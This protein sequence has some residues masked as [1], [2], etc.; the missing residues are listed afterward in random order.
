MEKTRGKQN[1]ILGKLLALALTLALA[2]GSIP[3]AMAATLLDSLFRPGPGPGKYTAYKVEVQS[4][5]VIIATNTVTYDP[6]GGDGDAVPVTVNRGAEHTV[7]NQGFIRGGYSFTGW[8]TEALG[9]GTP[10]AV[11][12]VITNVTNDITLYAQWEI[13]TYTITYHPN[14]GD[15]TAVTVKVNSGSDH[16]VVS[17]NYKYTLPLPHNFKGWNTEAL[18]GGTPYSVDSVITNVTSDIT[19]YAQW[20]RVFYVI[21]AP[22][23]GTNPNTGDGTSVTVPVEEGEVYEVKD[24]GFTRVGNIFNDYSDTPAGPGK[25]IRA[26]DLI[27]ITETIILF[28]RWATSW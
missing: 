10:Y 22:N 27:E 14:G 16:T 19:L 2:A 21:Y 11:D 6:N 20:N 12:S 17:Q 1:S 5:P 3:G 4:S 25:S 7:V 9:S 23:G 26:G 15:G 8:N 24:F 13:I 18:G 28:A